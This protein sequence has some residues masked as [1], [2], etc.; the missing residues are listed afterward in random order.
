MPRSAA[1]P[2]YDADRAAVQ[3]W[4]RGL[5]AAMRASGL[6]DVPEAAE[7]P[8]DLDR[9]WR[10]PRLLLSQTCGYPLV[11]GLAGVVQVVG[12]M[13]YSAPGCGGIGYRSELLVRDDDSGRILDDF[14][15]RVAAYNDRASQ[16]GCHSLRARVAPL[17]QNGRFFARAVETGAHRA[18]LALLQRGAAD[19]AAID[20]ITL[21]GLRRHA[22]E[23]TR[24]LRSIGSTALVPGLPLI[25]G[26]ATT[27]A[28]LAALRVALAAAVADPAL[29][30]VRAALFIAGFEPVAHEAW[31]PLVE[32]NDAASRLGCTEL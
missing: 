4:W 11:T 14:R 23:L 28:E 9:H 26:A 20:C 1:L 10:D 13:R 22:P 3:A 8:A 2:M 32:L 19:I 31:Q 6:R 27:P 24:G 15:G 7:W 21:A 16:S 30:E 5:A 17:A 29:A 18:S 12:A 25:T